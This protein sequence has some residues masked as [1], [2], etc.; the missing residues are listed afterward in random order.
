MEDF[1]CL[2]RD[3]L[4]EFLS[5][6]TGIQSVPYWWIWGLFLITIT[7]LQWIA[8]YNTLQMW[9]CVSRIIPRSWIAGSRVPCIRIFIR[10]LLARVGMCKSACFSVP[11]PI[12]YTWCSY[13]VGCQPCWFLPI[14]CWK[15]VSQQFVLIVVK[16]MFSPH[17]GKLPYIQKSVLGSLALNTLTFSSRTAV[18]TVIACLLMCRCATTTQ[19]VTAGT[20]PCAFFFF[21]CLVLINT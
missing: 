5:R 11:L 21:H 12:W 17:S 2:G 14:L 13:M 20:R 1:V 18:Y 7:I 19:I 16:Y 8:L 6:V 9:P 3:Y 15:I 10:Y 4:G